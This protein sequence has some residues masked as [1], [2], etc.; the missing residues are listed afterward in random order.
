VQLVTLPV[1][2]AAYGPPTEQPPVQQRQ[3]VEKFLDTWKL[4][5]EQKNIENYL[6]LYHPSFHAGTVTREKL[7]KLKR[8][9]FLKYQSVRVTIEQ[10]VIKECKGG[11]QVRFLQT[12]QGDDYT[13]KGWKTL[14]FT[15]S[16]PH[17][18]R[19][20]NEQWSP[21]HPGSRPVLASNTH[22]LSRE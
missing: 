6:K 9:Y 3:S 8:R 13:D 1:I 12:F 15:G 10:L 21:V 11:I 17:G 5:W 14:L 20:V 22:A 18:L 7:E 19:I 4:A 16:H 2:K